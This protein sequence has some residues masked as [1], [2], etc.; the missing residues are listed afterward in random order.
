MVLETLLMVIRGHTIKY[1]TFK[2][3]K[4]LEE[5]RKLEEEIQDLEANM[6]DNTNVI[7]NVNNEIVQT[8]IKKK[9]KK[10]KKKKNKE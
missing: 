7:L 10:K 5:E 1:S 3:K 4:S 8:L 9:K 6:N 2:K